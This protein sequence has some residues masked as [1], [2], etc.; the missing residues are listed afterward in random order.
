MK[1]FNPLASG[2]A[3]GKAYGGVFSFNRGLATFKRYVIP[4]IQNTAPQLV[5]KNRFSYLQKY[6]EKKLTFEQCEL[7]RAWPLPW[8]DSYGHEV[9]LTGIN[10]F[11]KC[12]EILNEASKPLTDTPPTATPSEIIATDTS[13]TDL[14]CVDVN[15]ISNAEITA[16]ADFLRIEILGELQSI[17][18]LVGGLIIKASGIPVSRIPLEKNWKA[19]YWYDCR[20]DLEGVQELEIQLDY[21]GSAPTLQG[22][23]VQRLNKYGYWSGI[24]T[25]LHPITVRNLVKNGR[26][27][28][29]VDWTKWF[30]AGGGC[31]IHD[32]KAYLVLNSYIQ[33]NLQNLIIGK[34]YQF[35]WDI[36][37]TGYGGNCILYFDNILSAYCNETKHWTVTL[38]YTGVLARIKFLSQANWSGSVDNVVM[39]QL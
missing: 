24:C 16:Q 39:K 20:P 28:I 37:Y 31:S 32:G 6:W 9:I 13:S 4:R 15:G 18:Y 11:F 10:K 27:V 1:L 29:D 5:R 19:V 38:V 8:W 17:L 14:I 34:T 12:N 7:W 30:D 25:Y 33:Q 36:I 21:D 26:F 22:L 3:S 23:R 35:D 2:K